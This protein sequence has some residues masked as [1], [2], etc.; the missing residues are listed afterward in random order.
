MG[1]DKTNPGHNLPWSGHWLA[2]TFAGATFVVYY[3][4]GIYKMAHLGEPTSI[5]ALAFSLLLILNVNWILAFVTFFF[6][7][8]RVPLLAPLAVLAAFGTYA[9]SSDHYFQVQ[10]GVTVSRI[11]PADVLNGRYDP[12]DPNRPLIV[13]TT[14]GGGIQAAAWTVRVLTG[15]QHQSLLWNR[16]HPFASVVAMISSVSGGAAGSM[17]FVDRY[18]ND[19]SPAG[20]NL[21]DDGHD[22]EQLVSLAEESSLDDIAWALVYKDVPRIF[23][24]YGASGSNLLLDRGR[25]LELSWQNRAR[26]F[27]NLSNW[28]VGVKEGWRPATI[29]NATIAE[30]GEPLL[31]STTDLSARNLTIANAPQRL[32]ARQNFADLYRD[33]DL[34]VTTAVRLA[35]AFPYVSPAARAQ[36]DRPE[37]HI[38]D[39][40]YYDNYGVANAID[41]INE[42][43]GGFHHNLDNLPPILVITIRSF[44]ND[45][46]GEATNRG[47]FFQAYAPIE[48]LLHVR[49][50]TQLVRDKEQLLLLRD[51]WGRNKQNIPHI[52]FAS[53]Q[54]PQQGAP[55]SWQMNDAQRKAIEAQWSAIVAAWSAHTPA[56]DDLAQVYCVLGGVGDDCTTRATVK[57]P[58]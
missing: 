3:A 27:S 13:I 6:D 15:L 39:G 26:I 32:P 24:P 28:R 33:V 2:I 54:F 36:M 7:R 19:L 22:L 41:W 43:I 21:I 40:G 16:S 46:M 53:F 38:V 51:R 45:A 5:P 8:F 49:T 48:G 35:S 14:A 20:F 25:M 18:S 17:F 12:K 31:F 37:Y 58:W 10:P 23:A 29:F 4:I 9:P 44:P 42:A 47:W 30:T 11:S 34:P 52:R 50:T 1:C 56:G 55:L 57:E